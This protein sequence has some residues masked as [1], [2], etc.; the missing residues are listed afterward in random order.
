MGSSWNDIQ[1][2]Q[3]KS[4]ALRL[5]KEEKEGGTKSFENTEKYLYAKMFIMALL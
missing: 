1:Q 3:I 5:L 2:K 4:A